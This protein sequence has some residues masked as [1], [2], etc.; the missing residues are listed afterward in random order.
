MNYIEISF[1]KPIKI[2]DT[3]LQGITLFVTVT[4]VWYY[5]NMW[6][7][8]EVIVASARDLLETGM[9]VGMV[10]PTRWRKG[11]L[12]NKECIDSCSE[13]YRKEKNP[14]KYRMLITLYGWCNNHKEFT[15]SLRT[16]SSDSDIE[17]MH[18]QSFK[19]PNSNKNYKRL[20]AN[21]VDFYF[22]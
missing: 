15:L 3:I 2:D 1:Q 6:T 8:Q 20:A 5:A 17:C 11:N 21:I 14:E 22:K 4:S 9:P 13:Y 16:W 7:F 19:F 10:F 12:P 18:L